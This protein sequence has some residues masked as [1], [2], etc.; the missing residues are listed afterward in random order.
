MMKFKNIIISLR[1]YLL[2]L[3]VSVNDTVYLTNSSTITIAIIK[4]HFFVLILVEE[5]GLY[6]LINPVNNPVRYIIPSKI[7]DNPIIMKFTSLHLCFMVFLYFTVVNSSI[8]NPDILNNPTKQSAFF[9]TK[10]LKNS[11]QSS[12]HSIMI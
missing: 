9:N 10:T 3:F 11:I 1:I 8:K 7:I 4:I 5:K 2:F 6:V 12:A